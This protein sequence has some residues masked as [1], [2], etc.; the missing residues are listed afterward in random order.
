MELAELPTVFYLNID[1]HTGFP[2]GVSSYDV[3]KIKKLYDSLS[4]IFSQQHLYENNFQSDKFMYTPSIISYVITYLDARGELNGRPATGLDQSHS[5]NNNLYLP[6]QLSV[7]L[8][9][10]TDDNKWKNLMFKVFIKC[11]SCVFNKH[12]LTII[13][14]ITEF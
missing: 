6:R 2:T 7:R 3:F 9:C 12:Y 5:I 4:N 10:L 8:T 13:I 14:W 11:D 1:C